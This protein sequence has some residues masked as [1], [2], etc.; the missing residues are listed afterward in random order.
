MELKDK[1]VTLRKKKGL[2]QLELAEAIGVSRQ[3]VSRWEV[4]SAIPSTSKIQ[5][6]S[7]LYGVPIE[8]LFNEN[9]VLASESKKTEDETRKG[10]TGDKSLRKDQMKFM[11]LLLILMAIILST[12]IGIKYLTSNNRSKLFLDE[13][14]GREIITCKDIKIQIEW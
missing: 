2:S 10:L 4:G 9:G 3:A 12:I 8:Y 6:L 5:A 1:L 13:L 7:I 11:V 14:Q